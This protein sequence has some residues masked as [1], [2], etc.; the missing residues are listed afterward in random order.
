M[1]RYCFQSL[2]LLCRFI[3]VIARCPCYIL[4]KKPFDA[5]T[6][7][8]FKGLHVNNSLARRRFKGFVT[9]SSW[10]IAWRGKRTSEGEAMLTSNAF[11]TLFS[12]DARIKSSIVNSLSVTLNSP[13]DKNI[14]KITKR[15][16]K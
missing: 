7:P 6:D 13:C 11:Y 4:S 12:F 8:I 1:Q 10:R 3:A 15:T 9:R 16:F 2:S 14:L 5:R